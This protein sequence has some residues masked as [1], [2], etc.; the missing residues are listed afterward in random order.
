MPNQT[1]ERITSAASYRQPAGFRHRGLIR[2]LVVAIAVS[3]VMLASAIV[4]ASGQ[5]T[6]KVTS[7]LDLAWIWPSQGV[8]CDSSVPDSRI[9]LLVPTQTTNIAINGT[10]THVLAMDCDDFSK[11]RRLRLNVIV[12]FKF[13]PSGYIDA[14]YR[15]EAWVQLCNLNSCTWQPLD[16]KDDVLTGPFT[17]IPWTVT[18][19]AVA[20][21]AAF[22]LAVTLRTWW[23]S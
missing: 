12:N 3:C 10:A 9:H 1:L 7:K 16:E 5:S 2:R 23:S 19:V 21:P 15:I 20:P 13:K 4:P 11:S 6:V 8:I 14:S 17:E 22:N 18:R